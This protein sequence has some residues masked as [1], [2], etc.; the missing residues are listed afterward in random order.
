M[1]HRI[2][3]A[4]GDKC[5][6]LSG[7]PKAR[8]GVVTAGEDQIRWVS[9]LLSDQIVVNIVYREP[10]VSRMRRLALRRFRSVQIRISWSWV[11]AAPATEASRR[12][13]Q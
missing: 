1:F 13:S 8:R 3:D 12:R 11:T 6:I 4:F 7:V 5:E 2:Y 10:S 9:R